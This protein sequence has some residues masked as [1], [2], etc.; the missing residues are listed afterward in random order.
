MSRYLGKKVTVE[1]CYAISVQFLNK[2]GY[3][4]SNKFQYGVITWSMNGERLSDV[5]FGV[6]TADMKVRFIYRTRNRYFE[7]NWTPKNY[8]V[9]LVSTPCYFGGLRYWFKC[10]QCS[11]RVGSLYLYSD[12]D[13]MCRHCL[14]LSYE[15]RNKSK[16]YCILD[17]L[18]RAEQ[19]ERQIFD[20][21]TK[22]YQGKPT[23]RY[24]KLLNQLDLHLSYL[25]SSM[26]D[27]L[28]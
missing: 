27:I 3:L 12:L 23:R 8:E 22:Y 19:I 2:H 24:Q 7:E 21:R 11:K 28:F 13:F 26:E 14:N 16:R 20:L 10:N 5:R 9:G 18:F 1:A 6:S 25:P 17:K 4:S 15:S